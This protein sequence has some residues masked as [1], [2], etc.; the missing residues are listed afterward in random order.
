MERLNRLP[1]PFKVSLYKTN[2]LAD[3]FI[4]S[5][6]KTWMFYELIAMNRAE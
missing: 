1:D 3:D 5:R 4:V 6:F 2:E